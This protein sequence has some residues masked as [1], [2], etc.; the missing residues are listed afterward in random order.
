M[1][2][3]ETARLGR[4]VSPNAFTRR[5][6]LVLVICTANRGR[7]PLLEAILKRALAGIDTGRCLVESAGLCTHELERT[8][9][10]ADDATLEV[11][12]RHGLDLTSHR[13]RPLNLALVRRANLVITMESWQSEVLRLVVPEH[14]RKF[15]TMRQ[16]SGGTSDI[17]TPDFAGCPVETVEQFYADAQVCISAAFESGPLAD[18]LLSARDQ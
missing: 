12:A 6:P 14:P 7:S 13:A 1:S 16:L 18:L 3:C 9:W 5:G 4:R 15:V 10:L 11:A 2:R 8:G 17:D